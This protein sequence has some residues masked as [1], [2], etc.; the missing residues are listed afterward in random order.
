MEIVKPG[1][2][3]GAATK[4]PGTCCECKCEFLFE[5]V[6]VKIEVRRGLGGR[7]NDFY[8]N[9]PTC[10]IQIFVPSYHH[11]AGNHTLD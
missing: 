7:Y 8:V 2:I 10:G 3:P 9:C 1:V 4:N 11:K 5:T 6:D